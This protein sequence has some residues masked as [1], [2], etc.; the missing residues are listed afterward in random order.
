LDK[1]NTGLFERLE[2]PRDF[3][4][5]VFA[6]SRHDHDDVVSVTKCNVEAGPQSGIDIGVPW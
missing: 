6:V 2:Q 1:V 5:I 4:G 3:T